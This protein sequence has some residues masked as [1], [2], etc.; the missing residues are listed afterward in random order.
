MAV[1]ADLVW[2]PGQIVVLDERLTDVES[3]LRRQRA[4]REQLRL[5]LDLID[6]LLD[7]DDE[8]AAP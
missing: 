1:S 6:Q 7:D 5:F 3:Y 4:Q 8:G 2:R